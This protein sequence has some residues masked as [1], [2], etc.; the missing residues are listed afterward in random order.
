MMPQKKGWLRLGAMAGMLL[1]VVFSFVSEHSLRVV[2]YNNADEPF[3][4]V[5]VTIGSQSAEYAPLE[6]QESV[7]LEFKPV[8][9]P[10]DVQ[11]DVSGDPPVHWSA[12]YLASG[13]VAEISLRV[14]RFGSVTMTM[15]PTWG[16]RL[17]RLLQ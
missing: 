14:D 17:A 9:A 11:L 3:E 13:E 15:E 6:A 16:R 8:G 4:R 5:H 2:I 10:A 7:S 12:P 1:A